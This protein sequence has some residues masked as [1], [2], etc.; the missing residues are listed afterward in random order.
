MNRETYVSAVH[1]IAVNDNPHD[2]TPGVVLAD[3]LTVA[4]VADLADMNP[5][6]VAYDVLSRRR[7]YFS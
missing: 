7:R 1:W 3:T 6:D 5:L 2:D 4:L